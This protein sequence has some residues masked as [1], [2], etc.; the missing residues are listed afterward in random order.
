MKF[1]EL[2]EYI[3][4][5][6]IK[7][8]AE[9][10]PVADDPEITLSIGLPEKGHILR[11]ESVGIAA[12]K[13][14][15]EFIQETIYLN[16]GRKVNMIAEVKAIVADILGEERADELFKKAENMAKKEESANANP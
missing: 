16:L 11:V 3:E 12:H 2:K 8:A 9:G 5:A 1:S 4:L 10:R 6:K 13:R 7:A 14:G 15:S